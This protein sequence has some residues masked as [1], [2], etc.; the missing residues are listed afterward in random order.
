MSSTAR[1][2]IRPDTLSAWKG[3]SLLIVRTNGECSDGEPLSGYYFR[4]ARFLKTLRLTIA[5]ALRNGVRFALCP[6][7]YLCLPRDRRVRRRRAWIG[8]VDVIH[9]HW[10]AAASH[11]VPECVGGYA[12][13][14]RPTL[15][16]YPRANAPQL[17]NATAFPLLLQSILGLQPVAPLHLLVVI[18]VVKKRRVPWDSLS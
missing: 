5:A 13:G 2:I 16:A 6:G 11:R 15:G 7:V 4:E 3:A 12:R 17:W 10:K 18:K 1:A 8:K 9:R 14:E